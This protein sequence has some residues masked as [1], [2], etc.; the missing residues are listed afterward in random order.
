ML[1]TAL[2]R[3]TVTTVEEQLRR[4][5]RTQIILALGMVLA[6]LV[7][8]YLMIGSRLGIGAIFWGFFIIA[9]GLVLYQ[10]RVGLYM[11]LFQK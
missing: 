3:R 9:A 4:N 8:G 2:T 10:P 1:D 5:R 7:A 11:L 6:S